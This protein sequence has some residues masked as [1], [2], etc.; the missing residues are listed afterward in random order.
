MFTLILPSNDIQPCLA[1]TGISEFLTESPLAHLFHFY[2][3]FLS[4]L[5]IF[6]SSQ[7]ELPVAIPY[8]LTR[9]SP[10][11]IKQKRTSASGDKGPAKAVAVRD[12]LLEIL[13]IAGDG[14]SLGR[15]GMD[16]IG[17]QGK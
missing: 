7:S 3:S 14:L 12:L 8:R 6:P 2:P 10:V 13:R 4:L 15:L 5:S 16:S 17:V 11:Q 9:P 1:L